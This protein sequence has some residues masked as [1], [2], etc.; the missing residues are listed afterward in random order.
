M[1]LNAMS[2]SLVI[3]LAIAAAAANPG[4]AQSINAFG[5]FHVQSA[6]YLAWDPYPCLTEDNGAVVNSCPLPVNLFFDLPIVTTGEKTIT[7]RDYWNGPDTFDPF[8]CVSYAYT[9]QSSISLQQ[10]Q[11]TFEAKLTTLKTTVNVASAND[12]LS[13]ICWQ[14]PPGEGLAGLKWNQ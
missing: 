6:T 9:G 14:V 11:V 7:I 12:T 4:H 10:A 13:V 5:S 1:K 3:G 2:L 8:N